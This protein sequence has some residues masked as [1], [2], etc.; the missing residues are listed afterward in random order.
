MLR[1]SK[2]DYV[3]LFFLLFHLSFILPKSESLSSSLRHLTLSRLSLSARFSTNRRH[4]VFLL[5]AAVRDQN[6][7]RPPL[8]SPSTSIPF[9]PPHLSLN[10]LSRRSGIVISADAIV[11]AGRWFRFR[12]LCLLVVSQAILLLHDL[13][14]AALASVQPIVILSTSSSSTINALSS[15]PP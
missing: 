8:L 2:I 1:N 14:V 7:R 10:F 12:R 13:I 5:I 3:S 11:V 6:R 15:L 9:D 4:R